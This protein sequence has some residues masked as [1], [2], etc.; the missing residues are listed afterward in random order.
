MVHI[1]DY[2]I[3]FYLYHAAVDALAFGGHQGNDGAF[4]HTFAIKF[5]VYQ[6]DGFGQFDD[7]IFIV[8]AISIGSADGEVEFV[9]YIQPCQL[10]FEGIQCHAQSRDEL[11]RVF[12]RGFFYEIF[13]S[14]FDRIQ[15]VGYGDVFVFHFCYNCLF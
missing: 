7:V 8:F 11:E 1:H 10:A 2:H 6:E 5:S 3:V 13:F 15:L 12:S 14:I 4:Y 9:S